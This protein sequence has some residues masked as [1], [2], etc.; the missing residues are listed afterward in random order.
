MPQE[1]LLQDP[2]SLS[3]ECLLPDSEKK[4]ATL[5]PFHFQVWLQRNSQYYPKKNKT[6]LSKK[7][8]INGHQAILIFFSTLCIDR[9]TYF[10]GEELQEKRTNPLSL[11]SHEMYSRPLEHSAPSHCV[12]LDF[13]LH[14]LLQYE[15]KKVNLTYLRSRFN[16]MHNCYSHSNRIQ[17]FYHTRA[18]G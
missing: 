15:R 1:H 8:N 13:Y 7:T 5:S 12:H 14:K 6:K 3:W 9:Y 10:T 11:V 18:T 16:F 17:Y 2:S 4:R